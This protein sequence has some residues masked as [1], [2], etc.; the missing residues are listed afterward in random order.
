MAIENAE[1]VGRQPECVGVEAQPVQVAHLRRLVSSR[2]GTSANR[3][4]AAHASFISALRPRVDAW[5]HTG[6]QS[7]N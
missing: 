7:I 5:P 2:T 1:E 4:T 6:A 3:G